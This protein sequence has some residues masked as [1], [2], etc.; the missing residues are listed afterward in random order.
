MENNK[1][2]K[3][4]KIYI[5]HIVLAEEIRRRRNMRSYEVHQNTAVVGFATPLRIFVMLIAWLLI[6]IFMVIVFFNIPTTKINIVIISAL[7]L[8]SN[9]YFVI[10]IP[11]TVHEW[12]F[13][14]RHQKY[15]ADKFSTEE[16]LDERNQKTYYVEFEVKTRITELQKT[17]QT[18]SPELYNVIKNLEKL[19]IKLH[20][21]HNLFEYEIDFNK[22]HKLVS[23]NK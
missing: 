2:T 7:L 22:I 20:I 3:R 10:N 21:G 15:F 17:F 6:N 4:E 12:C 19:P 9:I 13:Y 16:V 18:I 11:K 1:F 14:K 23:N 5:S 8:A